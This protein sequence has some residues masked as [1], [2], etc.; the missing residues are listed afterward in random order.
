VVSAVRSPDAPDPAHPDPAVTILGALAVLRLRL[1][2][3]RRWPGVWDRR[4]PVLDLG[5]ASRRRAADDGP[6]IDAVRE[7]EALLV[8]GATGGPRGRERLV[9]RLQPLAVPAAAPQ[10]DELRSVP[11]A[12]VLATVEHLATEV[13][14]THDD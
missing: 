10:L 6:P 14:R 2:L 8:A 11:S 1:A 4:E 5:P 3:G 9:R 7:W 12:H 13:E